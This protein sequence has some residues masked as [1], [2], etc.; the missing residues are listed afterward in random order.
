MAINT[1]IDQLPPDVRVMNATASVVF[2]IAAIAVLAALSGWAARQPAFDMD[3]LILRGEFQR[4][5]VATLRAA[6]LPR[7]S[8]NFF[9]MDLYRARQAFEAMPWVRRAVVHRVWP[10]N[11]VV[12]I[13]EHQP[14]AIWLGREGDERLVNVQGEVFEV[15]LG[16]IDEDGLPVLQG[17]AGTSAQMLDMYRRLGASFASMDTAP[18]KLSLSARGSWHVDLANGN[19]VEM[20]RGT[21]DEVVARVDRFV[22]TVGA[23]RAGTQRVEWRS[24]DLRHRDGYALT[25]N[26][27]AGAQRGDADAAD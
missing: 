22:R 14:A 10:D 2:V 26:T 24:A 13:E 11:L 25:M 1:A 20:G 4:N 17:P 5:N 8:G 16:D 3:R 15:N 6:V 23:V 21:D 12:D 18:V 9:T 7:L 19:D 27:A